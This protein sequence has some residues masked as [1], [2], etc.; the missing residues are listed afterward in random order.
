MTLNSSLLFAFH[1]PFQV[2]LIS[3]VAWT[4]SCP[5][6]LIYT[7]SL[8]QQAVCPSHKPTACQGLELSFHSSG[9]SSI[10]PAHSSATSAFP[11]S[12]LRLLVYTEPPLWDRAM[13]FQSPSVLTGL[14]CKPILGI[15][16]GVTYLKYWPRHP[17]ILPQSPHFFQ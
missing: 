7:D 5:V 17:H 9:M 16:L 14:P 4:V 11:F 2:Q 12:G 13:A 10:S 1:V 15:D 6:N 8:N 3:L